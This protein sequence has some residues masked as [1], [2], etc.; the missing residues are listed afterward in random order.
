MKCI[1]ISIATEKG[2]VGKT[3]TAQALIQGLRAKGYK[4]LGV[5]LDTQGNLTFAFNCDKAPY[6]VFELATKQKKAQEVIYKDFI[7]ASDYISKKD[8]IEASNTSLKEALEPIKKDYDFIIIDT[9]PKLDKTLIKALT[10]SDL[11]ILPT[12]AEAFSLKGID[13]AFKVV[14]AIKE[15]PN[16][17]KELKIAG[18]LLTMF[19]ER[20]NLSKQLKE[21]I[22]AKAK[23]YNTIVFK[24]TIARNVAIAE[25]QALQ[26]PLLT[27]R[28]DVK[29]IKNYK[30][31][32]NEF[33]DIIQK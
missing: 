33:L 26:E 21:L 1:T 2:G 30:D 6:S 7:R 5:D 29:A 16:G 19:N 27:Y 10:S 11:V 23:S 31:F 14:K 25:A 24:T 15:A 20:N 17:N 4:A 32:I 28:E 12:F 9:P 8:F 18:I 3:T 13:K 22:E